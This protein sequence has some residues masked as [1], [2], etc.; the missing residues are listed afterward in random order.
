M[1]AWKFIFDC[2]DL[3]VFDDEALEYEGVLD[4]PNSN[5]I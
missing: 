1:Q 4:D 5:I 3:D 2:F